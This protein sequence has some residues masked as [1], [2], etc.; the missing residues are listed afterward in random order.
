MIDWESVKEAFSL[1][2]FVVL[3]L[4][5]LYSACL[6]WINK[7]KRKREKKHKRINYIWRLK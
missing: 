1:F 4:L 5:L 6:L 2:V 7:G 3:F